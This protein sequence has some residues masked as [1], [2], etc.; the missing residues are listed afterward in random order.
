MND[1][2]A[3]V[4]EFHDNPP[5]TKSLNK[6]VS[7]ANHFRRATK[8]LITSVNDELRPAT[9]GPAGQQD[10]RVTLWGNN[11]MHVQKGIPFS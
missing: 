1:N 5:A 3:D 2:A 11:S 4:V 10:I 6:S 8:D 7:A 9:F